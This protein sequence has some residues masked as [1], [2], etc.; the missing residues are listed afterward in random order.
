MPTESPIM[1]ASAFGNLFFQKERIKPITAP[2]VAPNSVAGIIPRMNIKKISDKM[3]KTSSS[4]FEGLKEIVTNTIITMPYKRDDQN[5]NVPPRNNPS[6]AGELSRLVDDFKFIIITC[7]NILPARRTRSRST[8]LQSSG[9]D[10]PRSSPH[11]QLSPP[12]QRDLRPQ[13]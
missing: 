11:I 3:G 7:L 2:P 5:A 12:L 4:L 1:P 8:L 10:A 6:K 9:S 13:L